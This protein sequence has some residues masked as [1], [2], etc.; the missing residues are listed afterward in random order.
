M[1]FSMRVLLLLGSL[2]LAA[3]LPAHADNLLTNGDFETGDLTGWTVIGGPTFASLAN[4]GYNPYSG[5]YFAALGDVGYI[6]TLSQ[7]F[8]DTPGQ[9]YDLTFYL[10]SN[11]TAPNEFQAIIDGTTDF[12]QVD[13]PATGASAPYPYDAYSIL[14][15]GTGSDTVTFGE[16]D[17]PNYLALDDVSVST[18]AGGTS[19]T[20]EPSSLMLLGT[21]A[22]GVLGTMRRRIFAQ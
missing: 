5:S 9:T 18:V 7:T 15:T 11:G 10:A 3:C 8:T 14:F 16:R 21:G 20:P 13:I 22:L 19:V 4:Y 12:D 2:G 17:D 1:K 6:G